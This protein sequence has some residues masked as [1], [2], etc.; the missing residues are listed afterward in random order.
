VERDAPPAATDVED[1]AAR[2]AHRAPV[3][4]GPAA[5]GRKVQRRV[6]PTCVHKAVLTLD[7]L[8]RITAGKSR[9]KHLAVRV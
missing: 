9:E 6:K 2:V 1:A 3:V 5:E 8:D 7:D 4:C